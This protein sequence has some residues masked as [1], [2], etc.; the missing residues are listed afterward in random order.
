MTVKTAEAVCIGHPDK[1]CDLIAETILDAHTQHDPLARVAVEVTAKAYEINIF[2]EITSAH[3]ANLTECAR[4]ALKVAGYNPAQFTVRVNVQAQSPEIGSG[5]DCSVEARS[6]DSS[7]DAVLGAG[8]QGTVYGYATAETPKMLPAPLLIARDICRRLSQA[9]ESGT[10]TGLL[11][12]GKAQVSIRYQ[13]DEP[14]E[15][16]AVVVSAQHTESKSLDAL[17][18]EILERIIKPAAHNLPLA[19][20]AIILINP[21]GSFITGGPVADA[22]LT[23]RKLAVDTYG[24]LAAHG[25][26]AF[27]G[28][29]VS[30]VDRSAAL[31]ARQIA[32][33]IVATDLAQEATVAI[34]YAIG[35]ASP[36]AF[37]ITLDHASR[38]HESRLTEICETLF[39]LQPTAIINSLALRDVKF[40]RYASY[41][42]F[43]YDASWEDHTTHARAIK[44]RFAAGA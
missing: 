41:G 23:G 5:V 37:N 27:A 22:G 17:R 44:E 19:T 34:S 12:D 15:I 11:P 9:R 21:A 10:I 36:V 4:Q 6:G 2:G 39:P 28:K 18:A 7:A 1:L 26:G 14:R 29:D 13:G 31:L 25:G 16:T 38:A 8:D 24:G 30:K 20:D 40:V 32:K 3:T 43:G 33:S 35:K 42:Y